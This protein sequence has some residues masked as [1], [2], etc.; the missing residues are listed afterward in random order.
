[1]SNDPIISIAPLDH[2]EGFGV[3]G[4]QY[5]IDLAVHNTSPRTLEGKGSNLKRFAQWCRDRAIEKPEDVTREL[6]EHYQR[7]VHRYRKDNGKALSVGTQRNHITDV[8]M[9]YRWLVKKQYVLY[10]PVEHLELPRQPKQLPKGVLNEMEMDGLLSQPNIDTVAGLRDRAMMELLY[11][12][13]I[14]RKELRGLTLHDIDR[15]SGYV[16]VNNGKGQKDRVVPVGDRALLWLDRYLQDSRPFMVKDIGEQALFIS[17]YGRCLSRTEITR[18]FGEYRKQA[19]I[20][21]PGSVH[22]FR[23]TAATV[24]LDHGADIRHIQAMLGHE[25]LSTTQIYTHVAIT[26]LK[27]VHEQTHPAK[28]TSKEK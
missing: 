5:F 19:G 24:M 18:R 21:K 8:K 16:R 1:M 14:R 3:L 17:K 23:H 2:P 7:Y 20:E 15:H 9:F 13:G 12:S 11:S 4:K 22:I 26:Q 10:S 6:A 28:L 25:D 27:A